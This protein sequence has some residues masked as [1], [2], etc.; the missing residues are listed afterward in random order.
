MER[1]R[2]IL[3]S[4]GVAV[5]WWTAARAGDLVAAVPGAIPTI[6][7]SSGVV[8]AL[9]YRWGERLLPG[10][11]L[12][13]V[14]AAASARAP[15]LAAAIGAATAAAE[16]LF[17]ARVLRA[18]GLFNPSLGDVRSAVVLVAVAAPLMALVGA[19]GG[20]LA[21]A[22]VGGVPAGDLPALWGMWWLGDFIGILVVAP[23]AFTWV[24]R[25]EVVPGP[26]WELGVLLLTLAATTTVT[27]TDV[28]PFRNTSYPL[29]FVLVP[30]LVWSAVRHGPRGAASASFVAGMVAAVCTMAG[31]GPLAHTDPRSKLILLQSL[32]SVAAVSSLVLAGALASTRSM[33]RALAVTEFRERALLSGIPDLIFRVSPDGRVLEQHGSALDPAIPMLA[34]RSLDQLVA[35]EQAQAV[36]DRV[37]RA[38]VHG[39]TEAVELRGAAAL[40]ARDWEAR[41]VPMR[42]G[43]V[44]SLVRD[45]SQRRAAEAALRESEERYRTLFQQSPS[46]ILIMASDTLAFLDVNETAVRQYGWT[47]D[48]FRAMTARDIR[49]PDDAVPVEEM[50]SSLGDLPFAS[51]SP[52][53]HRRK[54]GAVFEVE[55]VSHP[56]RIQ[57]RDARIVMVNDVSE[58]TRLEGQLREAQRLE[59]IGRLV[60]GIAHDFNNLLTTVVGY[61][62]LLLDAVP[63]SDPVHADIR[64][65]LA[66]GRRG[67]QLTK[68]LLA[69][70]RQQVLAPRVVDLNHVLERLEPTILRLAGDRIRLGLDLC[71]PAPRVKTDPGQLEQILTNLVI[72]ARDAMTE[73]GRLSLR[74]RVAEVGEA[75]ASMHPD[76]A[77][78]RYA[79]LSVVD[80]GVG[81][82]EETRRRMFEPFFTTKP[83]G[84]A[85]GLGLSAV[86]GFVMQSGGFVEVETAPGEGTT[87]ALYLPLLETDLPSGAIVQPGHLPFAGAETVLC[88]EDEPSVRRL[89]R[90]ALSDRGYRVLVAASG[91]EALSMAAD[92]PGDIHVL[93]ADVVMP[94]LS[95][96]EVAASVRASRPSAR[97]LYVTGY[98]Q[99]A[100][101]RVERL[102][103]PVLHKPFS[104][105]QLARAVREVV[106]GAGG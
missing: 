52:W 65:I 27:F 77:P 44:L 87:M 67:T 18:A 66:A 8:L 29:A 89:M 1:G 91:M 23:V 78:G 98:G 51:A 84:Q 11:I 48:E 53:R 10:V 28:L 73:G 71:D 39:I 35:P 15:A 32:V 22:S 34:G 63:E 46:P 57:G 76:A 106:D 86:Y 25:G 72:N 103:A 21:L 100:G 85:A 105:E 61:S 13:A 36:R 16:V 40:G 81:M 80:D 24:N 41:F 104:P 7:L 47:R 62:E 4:I 33:A 14:L 17:G 69:F 79:V 5:A 93:V 101:M 30:F 58:R 75:E 60:G 9:V 56:V 96:P 54:D 3:G 49:P 70:S 92:H 74:T 12:G 83:L 94:K 102:D 90:R 97:V 59:A 19:T 2:T 99:T 64:E 6:C 50:M 95:G 43:T 45:V 38:A 31:L 68:Q 88:V 42:D 20:V 82:S 55:V 37:A 26:G